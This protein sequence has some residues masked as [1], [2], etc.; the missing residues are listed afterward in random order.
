MERTER[1]FWNSALFG[2]IV[3][4]T[5]ALGGQYAIETLKQHWAAKSMAAAFVG[6]ISAIIENQNT[7][8]LKGLLADLERWE[9]I[10][11]PPDRLFTIYEA[12]A[13]NLGLLDQEVVQ[14]IARFYALKNAE[15]A[16]LKIL[17]DG[18][19]GYTRFALPDKKVFLNSYI[20]LNEQI[21][22]SGERVI[23]KLRA[24]YQLEDQSPRGG[25][26]AA[27]NHSLWKPTDS[28]GLY[29]LVLAGFTGLL[30]C[31]S[32]VQG[33]FL[34]AANKTARITAYAADRQARV[35]IAVESPMPLFVAFKLVQFSTIPGETVVADPLAPGKIQP[36]CRI[37]P[38]LE[39][40]GRTPL[41]MKE[42]C[43]EK[44]SG[45]A[46]PER[47]TYG[48]ATPFGL[49]LE[50]GPIW[51]RGAD[52]QIGISNTEALEA[53]NAFK[54]AGAF[55][56]Y[57]YISYLTLLDERAE[58]K[59]LWRWDQQLGFVPENRPGFS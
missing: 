23:E 51:I 10:D 14:Q 24:K 12:A 50:K 57:G 54:N 47:P 21:K 15:R 44:Y 37:F 11:Q 33:Y 55:W 30:V 8:Y 5:L 7:A 43:I 25:K 26:P 58:L 16:K 34:L 4:A 38:Y 22:E 1:P 49:V 56:V 36:N 27:A 41:R 48:K 45:T 39:N 59:F 6:E 42:F 3:G 28:L 18:T 19:R 2:V 20:A 17:G 53:E 13:P 29:T 32:G 9:P 35:M 40:K 52:E 46:L 31:V